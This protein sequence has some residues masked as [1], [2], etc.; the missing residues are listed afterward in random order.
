MATEAAKR[1]SLSQIFILTYQAFRNKPSLY[2]PFIIFAVLEFLSLMALFLAPRAPFREVLGP[3]IKAFWGE[4]FLHYPLNFL[5]L[6]KLASHAR[7]FLSVFAGSLLTGIAVAKLYKKPLRVAFKRY[8]SLFLVVLIVTLLFY[9]L[10]KIATSG[11]SS[12]FTSG[13]QRLL[14]I[15]QKLW[16]GPILIAINLMLAVFVQSLFVYVIPLLILKEDGFI[17]TVI[18]SAVFLRGYFLK[19]VFLVALP[20]LAYIPIIVLNYNTG[21]LIDKFFPECILLIAVGSIVI[22]SLI[23]DPLVTVS[24]ALLYWEENKL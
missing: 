1:P 11:I 9:F 3:P 16:M 17:P 12:Y 14:F 10:V 2:L 24:T 23:I 20:M 6:P 19:T 18:K 8:L 7:T 22:T 15:G 13:H 4:R 21:F 5:L